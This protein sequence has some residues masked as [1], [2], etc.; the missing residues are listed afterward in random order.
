MLPKLV[1]DVWLLGR[2]ATLECGIKTMKVRVQNWTGTSVIHRR[3]MM[4][5]IIGQN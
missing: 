3:T 5:R 1:E 4:K 2:M